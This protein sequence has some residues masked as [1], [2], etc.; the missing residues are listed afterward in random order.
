MVNPIA[1]PFFYG[2]QIGGGIDMKK[3]DNMRFEHAIPVEQNTTVADDAGTSLQ[4]NANDNQLQ[5]ELPSDFDQQILP[6]NKS[7]KSLTKA[8]P[9]E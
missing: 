8:I 9:N 2:R 6:K 5:T 4:E 3:M 1:L 7:I